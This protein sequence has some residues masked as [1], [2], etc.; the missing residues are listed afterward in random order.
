MYKDLGGQ[1]SSPVFIGGLATFILSKEYYVVTEETIGLFTICGVLYVLTKGLSEPVSK[2]LRKEDK[3]L[4]VMLANERKGK[5]QQYQDE[6]AVVQEEDELSSYIDDIFEANKGI[7]EMNVETEYRR[8]LLE[9]D[10]EV[11]KRLNYQVELQNIER[12]IEER[13][14][15]SWV[16]Q[17]VIKSISAEQEEDTLLKCI[18]DLNAL[19]DAKAV[20]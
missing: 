20:A 16:E 12:S 14:M 11:T 2:W 18:Q 5:V 17:E 9:V 10:T 8:R 1:S 13:H 3:A 19:A 4:V 15:A 7:A 6:L